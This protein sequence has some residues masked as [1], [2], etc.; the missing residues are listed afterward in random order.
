MLAP[1]NEFEFDRSS[2][3]AVTETVPALRGRTPYGWA[4][5]VP[6][7][8]AL[9]DERWLEILAKHYEA[10]THEA[11]GPG[12]LAA[13]RSE[14]RTLTDTFVTLGTGASKWSV[15]AEFELPFEGGRRPDIV[16]LA[17]TAVVVLEYKAEPR[18]SQAH[19]DQASAYARDLSEYHEASHFRDVFAYVVATTSAA[20]SDVDGVSVIAPGQ[21]AEALTTAQKQSD[22]GTVD[23]EQ[24]LSAPYAP[25][26][27]LVAAAR[28]I[29]QEE[30]L[31][32][33]RRAVAAGL[34]GVVT[35]VHELIQEARDQDERRLILITGV[36][37]A[38]KTL[39][40]LRVVYEHGSER[41]DSTF[42]SG[43]GPLVTVLQDALKSSV[44][45]RDLHKFIT[46]YGAS[47]RIPEQ[48]VLVF[49]EAQRAWD[50]EYME[51]K[52]KGSSSEPD[53]LVAIADRLPEWAVLVGLV[54]EGQEIH[55][56]EE[57]GLAQ[58]RVAIE[59]SDDADAWT[60][61]CPPSL[62]ST[63]ADI[64]VEEDSRLALRVSMRARRADRVADWVRLL[65]DGSI[66][67][68]ADTA[69]QMATD[70]FPIYVTRSLEEA[71]RH[72]EE[73]YA[74]EPD[75]RYGLIVSSHAKG[76]LKYGIDNSFMATN[77]VFNVAKWF[78]GAKTDSASCCACERVAT[79]FGCQGLEL[80]LPI[81]CWGSDFMWTGSAWKLTPIRRRYRQDDPYK[82]LENTYRVLLTRG[83]DGLVLFVPPTEEFTP[84][85]TVLLEGGAQQ[86]AASRLG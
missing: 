29:F 10:L 74:G 1:H 14:R 82:L 54:G 36:P 55:S 45:V 26:P 63:F 84:T 73:R 12:Q 67:A 59:A 78:N 52:G 47:N 38:G 53:L 62:A 64:H 80:D 15:V 66:Q 79:E 9:S 40:G 39:V 85:A 69:E 19:I 50:R 37:G 83:R 11:A 70:G 3:P 75:A 17:G 24:W 22:E 48:H 76:L 41:A 58:W 32:H 68:A 23:L 31:P 27:T 61:V 7:F 44:F 21:I 46:S 2:V 33:V 42:L 35:R 65:L 81:V 60:V 77:R 6:Q 49:D 18:I 56:G 34:P 5:S 30:E 13:W 43:N 20:L 8:L 71:K 16:V 86:L 4:G 72:A 57:G 51:H 25:L 28:R